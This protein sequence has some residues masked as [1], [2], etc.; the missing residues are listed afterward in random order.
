MS[1]RPLELIEVLS[2]FQATLP[3]LE[4]LYRE[5]L[6]LMQAG[7]LWDAHN[8]AQAM[9][10]DGT[11]RNDRQAQALACALLAGVH[12][13][14]GRFSEAVD[15]AENCHRFFQNMGY[16]AQAAIGH[17]LLAVIYQMH[18]EAINRELIESLHASREET[19][20]LESKALS[21]GNAHLQIAE[22]YR[23]QFVEFGEVIRRARW[24]PAIPYTL[25]LVWLPVI[26]SIPHE[27][28]TQKLEP[29]GYLEP[30]LFVLKGK[31]EIEREESGQA[32]PAQMADVLYTARPL[33]PFEGEEP[34]PLRPP[35]LKRGAIYA[36]I[37]VDPESA[38][39]ARLQPDD[40]L[41][42]RSLTPEERE[43]LLKQP[44]DS[45]AS[46]IFRMNDHGQIE[47][48]RPIPPKFV[49]ERHIIEMLEAKV[50]A[51]LRKVP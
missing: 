3:E 23:Q 30:V 25:P 27:L 5:A 9:L 37:K 14:H 28:D 4:R 21:K 39:L 17:A 32:D 38:H 44:D 34:T 12:A 1:P 10:R 7:K 49:G 45:S 42:V 33:P 46:F 47:V 43:Q 24:V 48:V 15:Q 8:R 50:D 13:L 40:Y 31:R 20:D 41:L 22:Q 51:V 16:P 11:T 35:Q 18:I 29:L 2:D 6:D 36:A 26:N 19:Q